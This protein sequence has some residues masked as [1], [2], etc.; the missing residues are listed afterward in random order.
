MPLALE[1]LSPN[2]CTAREV[3]GQRFNFP[4]VLLQERIPGFGEGRK[5]K[6]RMRGLSSCYLAVLAE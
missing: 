5:T 6:F 1:E 4:L 3:P 2:H